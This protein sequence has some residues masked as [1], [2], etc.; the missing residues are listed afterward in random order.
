MTDLFG[1]R[2]IP[3]QIDT[4]NVYIP[5]G[6]CSIVYCKQ[7]GNI[8]GQRFSKLDTSLV[9]WETHLVNREA[10]LVNLDT[11]FSKTIQ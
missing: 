7:G 10:S 6:F 5:Q 8:S 9:N 4:K 1:V 11:Q 3:G 2:V